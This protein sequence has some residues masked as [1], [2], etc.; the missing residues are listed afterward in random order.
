MQCFECDFLYGASTV[1]EKAVQACLEL[2]NEN[3]E[4][5]VRGI[6]ETC[7]KFNNLE[8]F[9]VTLNQSDKIEYD[10]MTVNVVKA[11]DFF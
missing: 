6:V 8:G 1:P 9:I 11:T 7:R 3:R 4:R 10:G 2:T 5:E